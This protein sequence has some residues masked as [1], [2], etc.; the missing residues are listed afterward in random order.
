MNAHKVIANQNVQDDRNKVAFEYG[1]ILYCAEEIDNDK[2][3]S[4]LVI[5]D[6]VELKIAKRNILSDTVNIITANVNVNNSSKRK[7]YIT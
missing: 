5:P 7:K 2:Q 4:N 1:P 3:L 6:N